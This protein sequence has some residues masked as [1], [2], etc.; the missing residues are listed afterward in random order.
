MKGKNLI[1]LGILALLV[2]I[3]AYVF[4]TRQSGTIKQELKDFAIED[5]ASITRI[6][7]ADKENRSVDLKRNAMG[8]WVVNGEFDAREDAIQNLL[9]TIRN[10]RVK[11]P[12]G[13]AA[14]DNVIKRMAAQ[15]VKIEIYIDGEK[16]KVY[17]VGYETP[18]Q[19]GTYMLLENSSRPFVMHI[20][21]FDGY[22]STRYFTKAE[23]WRERTIF[24]IEPREIANI[25]VEYPQQP[26][27]SFQLTRDPATNQ[28]TLTA[29]ATGMDLDPASLDMELL[30]QYFF[31][32]RKVNY[33]ALANQLDK[34]FR[35]SVAGSV[36][37][38]IIS[39]QN[40]EG[41]TVSIRTFPKPSPS[42]RRDEAGNLI[43]YDVDRMY[44]VIN[45]GKD[46]VVIQ[47]YVFDKIMLPLSEFIA[48][49]EKSQS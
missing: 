26:G 20:P 1:F 13:K 28:F 11:A 15:A 14:L 12:V 49:T 34:S 29:L 36:P 2:V 48:S 45:D 43:P 9:E 41:Q 39:V 32:F 16:S 6:F 47:Y 7:M 44:A 18:D 5:T 37:M 38:A 10:V 3:I 30:Q 35:D 23:D 31:H 21:G 27:G 24:N 17:H 40:L 19:L 8:Q 4:M 22:L 25:K 33:E 42:E 46:F